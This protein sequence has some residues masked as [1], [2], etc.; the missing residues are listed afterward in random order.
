[1]N[2]LT[3]IGKLEPYFRRSIVSTNDGEIVS[4]EIT[5]ND[6]ITINETTIDNIIRICL[7]SK[8]DVTYLYINHTIKGNRCK[9]N[10]ED[11]S[12]VEV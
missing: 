2:L 9:I 8:D 7:H 4:Y 12:T 5:T 10:I 11:I 1:M 3:L 6:S